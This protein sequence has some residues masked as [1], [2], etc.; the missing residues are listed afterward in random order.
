MGE[1]VINEFGDLT[2]AGKTWQAGLSGVTPLQLGKGL[3]A[4]LLSKEDWQPSLPKF[5]AMCEASAPREYFTKPVDN[6]VPLPPDAHKAK[7]ADLKNAIG[8]DL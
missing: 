8:G 3:K 6:Y 4:L 5:R 2:D 7:I 1:S